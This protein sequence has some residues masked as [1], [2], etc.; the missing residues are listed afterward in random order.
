[1]RLHTV[2]S[3]L[4]TDKKKQETRSEAKKRKKKRHSNQSFTYFYAHRTDVVGVKCVTHFQR[5]KT[6]AFNAQA[7]RL[8]VSILHWCKMNET[9]KKL[10]LLFTAFGLNLLWVCPA[11]REIWPC[12]PDFA[13]V[14]QVFLLTLCPAIHLFRHSTFLNFDSL[15]HSD[16][17]D[18]CALKFDSLRPVWIAYSTGTRKNFVDY[19]RL[20]SKLWACSNCVLYCARVNRSHSCCCCCFCC[21]R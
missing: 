17:N 20:T 9:S 15:F 12:R 3:V 13:F 6:F 4:H 21:C 16:P 19:L 2:H 14:L 11:A 8:F 7:H 5:K 18:Y 10:A 1:M